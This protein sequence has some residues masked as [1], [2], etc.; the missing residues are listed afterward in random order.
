MVALLGDMMSC[1]L[2]GRRA[3]PV[4]GVLEV[5]GSLVFRILR[6]RTE[7]TR[8]RRLRIRRRDLS[9]SH[10]LLTPCFERANLV[11]RVRPFPTAAMS[12]A[13]H[14]EETHPVALVLAHLVE[15]ALVV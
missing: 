13:R 7:R 3:H 9:R 5:P 15:D 1:T 12:H 6:K 11:E 4:G 14:H 2:S 10:P 8:Q